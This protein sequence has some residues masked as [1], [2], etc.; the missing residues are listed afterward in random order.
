M[1]H[2]LI[3]SAV[4]RVISGLPASHKFNEFFQNRITRSLELTDSR[5]EARLEH[6]RRHFDHLRE[7]RPE[8][9]DGFSV[10]EIGTGWF[11][12]VP[13][14]LFL[15]GAGP[16]WTFDISPLL[17]SER[18]G[19]MLRKFNTYAQDGRL[20][21]ILPGTQPSRVKVLQELV[22]HLPASPVETLARLNITA[23]TREA[24]RTGL[25][26]SSI[27]LF[28]STGVLE[29]IPGDVLREILVECQRVG[30]DGAVQSHYL[31]L[32]DQ[33]SYFDSSITAFNFLKYS[34]RAWKYLNSPLT[35]QNR[36]RISDFRRLFRES[37]YRVVKETCTRGNRDDLK[38]VRLAPEFQHYREEDLLVL[39][40]WIAAVA[41]N[42]EQA[43][44]L[45]RHDQKLLAEDAPGKRQAQVQ[46]QKR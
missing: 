7:F 13:V 30:R 42:R 25:P 39:F 24:Q 37:G 20:R 32:V 38:K 22:E 33:F 6:C 14:G 35:W 3:K 5:F 2:W 10:V 1:P 29:Y 4:Q 9:Q 16:I 41:E 19:N 28:T 15:C 12:V 44:S 45:S 23:Q 46:P 26:P 8:L 36:F 27:D 18:V 40:A 43:P 31:N 11:P 17:G 21:R 34:A